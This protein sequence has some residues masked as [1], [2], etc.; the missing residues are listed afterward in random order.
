M[1]KNNVIITIVIVLVSIVLLALWYFLGFNEID[2]PL[3]LLLSILWWVVIVIAIF[4]I[5]KVEKTRQEKVRTIYI[6]PDKLYNSENGVMP[7]TNQPLVL[8]L[9]DVL[10][11]LEYN[12]TKKDGPNKDEANFTYVVRSTTFKKDTDGNKDN[13]EPEWKGEVVTVATGVTQAFSTKEELAQLLAV[14]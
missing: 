3:D 2:S 4:A 10:E 13:S 12:F 8:A 5:V 7:R 1:K 9:E 11:A 6:A 14:A